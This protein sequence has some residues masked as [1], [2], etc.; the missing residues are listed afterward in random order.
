MGYTVDF[1][2]RFIVRDGRENALAEFLQNITHCPEK[3]I[4]K[5]FLRYFIEASVDV[6]TDNVGRTAYEFSGY[7]EHYHDEDFTGLA[8]YV[9]GMW[10][11]EGEDGQR[12]TSYWK[13]GTVVTVKPITVTPLPGESDVQAVKRWL[14]DHDG[15]G[16]ENKT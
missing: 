1:T 2:G 4:Q 5:L 7:D 16:T 14:K 11:C 13:D 12:W 8:P 10:S 6:E 9:N 15:P 3:D